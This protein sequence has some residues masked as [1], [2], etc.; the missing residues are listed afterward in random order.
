MLKELC[1]WLK[2]QRTQDPEIMEIYFNLR[3]A[4]KMQV[5]EELGIFQKQKVLNVHMAISRWQACIFNDLVHSGYTLW[6]QMLKPTKS[7]C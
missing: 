2:Y 1:N 3:S 6:Q 5:K 7:A 4:D